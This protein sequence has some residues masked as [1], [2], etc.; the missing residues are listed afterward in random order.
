MLHMSA[1]VLSVEFNNYAIFF[2]G[3]V[4]HREFEG[5]LG[6]IASLQK[7][8]RDFCQKAHLSELKDLCLSWARRKR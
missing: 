2:K 5:N 7:G 8:R 4:Q 6:L 1:R 3:F